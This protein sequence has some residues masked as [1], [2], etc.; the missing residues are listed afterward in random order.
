[1]KL[2][3]A[4]LVSL[5]AATGLLLAPLSSAQTSVWFNELPSPDY[6]SAR[7]MA[8]DDA[9]R[10]FLAG[11]TGPGMFSA[12]ETRLTC[13]SAHGELIW[14]T[15]LG[16]A[17]D[18]YPNGVCSDG[19]DG[20]FVAGGSYNAFGGQHAGELDTWLARHDSQGQRT[21]ILQLGTTADDA[22]GPIAPDG[23]GGAFVTGGTRGSLFGGSLGLRDA[24]LARY[25]ANGAR[26]WG[27]QFGTDASDAVWGTALDS[28]GGA[29]V[30]GS[31]DG[32]FSG[33][34]AGS[35]DGWL[36][37]FDPSGAM[38]WADQI[39]SSGAEAAFSV[40]S[41]GM[42]GA[43]VAGTSTGDVGGPSA[44]SVDVWVAHYDATGTRTWIRQFG[45]NIAD[46]CQTVV[47]DGA[48]GAF[49][50]GR[51]LGDLGGGGSSTGPCWIAHY[52]SEGARLSMTQFG[53]ASEIALVAGAPNPRGG[54]YVGGTIAPDP[55][56]GS[57][58]RNAWISRFDDI[59]T[60]IYCAP[61][62]VN[63]TGTYGKLSPSGSSV[64]AENDVVIRAD[65]L[66]L[67][68]FGY[69]I[70]SQTRDFIQVTG[71]PGILCLGDQVGRFSHPAQILNSGSSGSFT[72]RLNLTS[73]PQPSGPVAVQP[74][75]TW[76]FQAWYRDLIPSG[77]GSN[78][79]EGLSISFR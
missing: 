17:I 28:H 76:H 14:M 22:P 33:V 29:L 77:P 38:T 40:A 43:F 75:D 13:H 60:E 72:L 48:G 69:F 67:D 61:A 64:V 30:C 47:S 79:T 54:I 24:W 21:W 31:T 73:F 32:N 58:N 18:N 78:F 59:E 25:D 5:A 4:S 68:S 50:G 15:D 71:F 23:V 57:T 2:P 53:G 36:A 3:K 12:S 9:G 8:S 63:S 45:S 52:D 34:P 26:L 19:G 11:Q 20:L 16:L 41:D 37:R 74:G 6:E 7:V 66:P 46:S 27:I 51:S 1:M 70:N 10:V 35:S 44:G 39:S 42:G 65:D 55:S 56:S 49:L 62:G